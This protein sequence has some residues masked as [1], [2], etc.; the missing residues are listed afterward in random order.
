MLQ[1]LKNKAGEVKFRAKLFQQ[2]VEGAATL[3][4]ELTSTEMLNEMRRRMVI[5][6]R[7]FAEIAQSG[8]LQSPFLELGAE[9]GQRSLVLANDFGLDGYAADL[10]FESLRYADFLAQQEKLSKMPQRVCCDAYKLPFADDSIGFAF[11]YQT[12]HH[13]PDP[14]P[15]FRE[16]YRVLRPGAVLHVDEEPIRR[17]WKLN[18]WKRRVFP[19]G[20]ENK[21]VRYAKDYLLDFIS[22]PHVSEVDYGIC[23]NDDISLTEWEKAI[24]QV[25][26][27]KIR[28][29]LLPIPRAMSRV[30]HDSERWG[31][32]SSMCQALGGILQATITAKPARQELAMPREPLCCPI[33]RG[34]LATSLNSLFCERCSATYPT[35]DGI[36]MLL[37]QEELQSLYPD[38][39]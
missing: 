19:K 32:R 38:A 37:P 18:L 10:S 20:R 21:Y 26:N 28:L 15:I 4:G 17:T 2:Q 9:R 13:F 8:V 12:L 25:E 36:L 1:D 39:V 29:K 35:C 31:L 34:P 16:L 6:R 27:K 7:D 11:C 22:E 23:E 24:G 30:T 5:T 33:C 14:T 3:N